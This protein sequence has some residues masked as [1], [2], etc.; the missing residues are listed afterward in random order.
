LSWKE[1][2]ATMKETSEKEEK[3]MVHVRLSAD[4]VRLIDHMA[5]DARKYRNEMME[6]LLRQAVEGSDSARQYA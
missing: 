2:V 4:L 6:Q 5:V 3:E 1:E